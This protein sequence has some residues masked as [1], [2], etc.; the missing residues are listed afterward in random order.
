MKK[1]ILLVLI[2]LSL[3]IKPTNATESDY[4]TISPTATIEEMIEEMQTL[5]NQENYVKLHNTSLMCIMFHPNEF[6][7]YYYDGTA[8]LELENIEY[9]IKYLSIAIK[10]GKEQNIKELA[11]AYLNRSMAYEYIGDTKAMIKDLY[12]AYQNM[13]NN[14]VEEDKTMVLEA[15]QN[16][17]QTNPQD[18]KKAI[19]EINNEN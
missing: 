10:I 5:Y 7:G 1:I 8:L 14:Y 15:L 13:D 12:R 2:L 19:T 9:S 18:Y 17:Q 11:L 4:A 3:G 16:L 6:Y